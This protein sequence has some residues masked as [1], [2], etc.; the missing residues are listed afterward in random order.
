M[1][2]RYS[3]AGSLGQLGPASPEVV[4]TLIESLPRTDS[5]S[6]RRDAARLLGQIGTVEESLTLALWR[7]L[8]D[9]DDDVRTACAEA[10]ALLGRRFPD[11]AE[12]IAEKLVQAI[13]DPAFDQPDK[14]QGRTGHDYAFDG[15]WLLV[16]GGASEG[17]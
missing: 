16:A 13:T 5:W 17:G 6:V 3:A 8:S 11:A 9:G 4:Q 15:L 14:Y 10:L 7:G 1:N 12:T 2:V